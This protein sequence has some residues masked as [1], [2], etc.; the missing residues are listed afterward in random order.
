MATSTRPPVEAEAIVVR[1]AATLIA[2]EPA[3]PTPP[4]T[5]SAGQSAFLLIASTIVVA[6]LNY[7]L[8]IVLAWS[9]PADQYGRIGV[10]QTL[11][12]VL[13]WFLGAGFPW[14]VAKALAR[15]RGAGP[16]DVPHGTA[17]WR[18]YKTAWLAN[19]LLSAGLTALLLFAFQRHW[20]PLGP[21]YAPLVLVAALTI[22]VLGVSAV[23]D[24]GLQ[25]LLR[26]ERI[27][28]VRTLEAVVNITAS[29]LLVLLG[30]GATG[31]LGGFALAA[32]VACG[33]NIWFMRDQ[34][35][36]RAPGWGGVATMR[37]ALPMLLAVFGGILLTNGDVLA[38]KFLTNPADADTL[39]GVYQVAAILARAPLFV[40]T[41][42]VSTFY[43]HIAREE[44]GASGS[45]A[46]QQ[47]L[48]WLALGVLP[49]NLIMIV[50]A[51][52][53]V[54]FFFPQR[55]A[56]SATV[57]MVL[58]A[59]SACLVFANAIAATLQ[60]AHQPHVPASIMTG[61]VAVQFVGLL[62]L[63][64]RWG[65]LGAAL[66]AALASAWAC[67]LLA[68]QAARYGLAVPRWRQQA[69]ALVL[70][71]VA[72]FP[73]ARLLVQGPRIAVA[74]WV[75]AAVVWYGVACLVL[76]VITAD[77]L[78]SIARQIERRPLRSPLGRALRV[79][80]ALH[81]FGRCR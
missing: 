6:V 2:R 40:G 10:I 37:A 50:A 76:D 58:A 38:V 49:L 14:V 35:F 48:R 78:S 23:P 59:G 31:A 15:A 26:F 43:P 65:T 11:I 47:L 79:A 67:L 42:L 81:R 33:L 53:I 4:R 41:A 22:A 32:L 7:A 75:A 68:R 66:A 24:A 70:L 25:G 13:V 39:S 12:F 80:Y 17:A 29:V 64:P 77:D 63:V 61:A 71:L 36:W 20:L 18:T 44:A 69:M 28:L 72:L 27:A 46:G 9:L 30:F 3:T 51:P 56:A 55:Y 19:A 1:S 16:L 34:R 45:R 21:L 8:N 57:L 73:L 5:A 52:A 62:V 60:A 74:L 54:H